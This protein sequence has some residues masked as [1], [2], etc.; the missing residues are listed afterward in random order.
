MLAVNLP[1][2]MAIF[3]NLIQLDGGLEIVLIEKVMLL[4]VGKEIVLPVRKFPEEQLIQ[5]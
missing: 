4:T 2:R 5:A 1:V 3:G